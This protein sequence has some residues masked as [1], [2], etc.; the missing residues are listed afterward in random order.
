MKIITKTLSLNEL[1][2]MAVATFGNLVK[3]VV[4]IDRELIAVDAELHSDL[5]ALLLENG[6]KQKSLWGI[7]LYPEIQG[8]DFVEF[9]SMI[10]M[11]PSQGNRSRG[12]EN[13]DRRKKIF[14][15]I[16]KRIKR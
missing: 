11:R 16:A 2:Q 1:K 3:S 5:E 6:S 9:D 4:D 15:I 10:N 13:E 7:N 8:D 14:E 12:I